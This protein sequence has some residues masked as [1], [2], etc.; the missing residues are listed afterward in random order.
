MAIFTN[1]EYRVSSPRLISCMDNIISLVFDH[2]YGLIQ[3]DGL[4]YTLKMTPI[5]HM[6]CWQG[7]NKRDLTCIATPVGL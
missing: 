2:L 6:G 7:A 3:C 1:D 4:K 5:T